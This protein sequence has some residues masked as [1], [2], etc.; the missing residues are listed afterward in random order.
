MDRQQND[1]AYKRPHFS[2]HVKWGEQEHRYQ[3]PPPVTHVP[4]LLSLLVKA[5][6]LSTGCGIQSSHEGF[7]LF[8]HDVGYQLVVYTAS[9][10]FQ[11]GLSHF[12]VRIFSGY[13]VGHHQKLIGS[14]FFYFHC[15]LDGNI[16]TEPIISWASDSWVSVAVIETI[17]KPSNA[18]L[19]R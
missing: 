13:I 6:L 17:M 11:L 1:R 8:F 3:F 15:E 4:V 2:E 7:L 9:V 12:L 10:Q 19:F 16:L 5:F 18:F 14:V